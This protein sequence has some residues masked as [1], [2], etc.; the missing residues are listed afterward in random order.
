MK[1]L[2]LFCLVLFATLG[3]DAQS[4]RV[5]QKLVC[6]GDN[7]NVRTGPGKNHRVYLMKEG[8]PICDGKDRS[9]YMCEWAKNKKFQL[10][11]GEGRGKCDEGEWE[12]IYQGK[13]RNGFLYVSIFEC[14]EGYGVVGWVSSQYLRPIY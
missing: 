1:R 8:C 2:F 5:G 6:T 3:V 14:V 10:M 12:I 9:C 11:K 4:Y 13:S 7:V